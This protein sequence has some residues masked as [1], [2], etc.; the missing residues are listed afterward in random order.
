VRL[1]LPTSEGAVTKTRSSLL[2]GWEMT[3]NSI[4]VALTQRIREF[5]CRAKMM[6]DREPPSHWALKS[7]AL[8]QL[9][10]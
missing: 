10:A 7:F 4:Q 3:K 1:S 5:E 6:V 8:H 9:P 2:L